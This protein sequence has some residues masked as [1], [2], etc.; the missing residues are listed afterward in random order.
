MTLAQ[1][2]PAPRRRTG[3]AKDCAANAEHAAFLGFELT[4]IRL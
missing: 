4:I 3:C 2:I 1:E